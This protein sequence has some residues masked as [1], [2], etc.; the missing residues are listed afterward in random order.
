MSEEPPAA[1]GTTPPVHRISVVVPVYQGERTL[2][3][4][5]EE[6]RPMTAVT[7]SP[8]GRSF[9]IAELILVHDGAADNSHQVM[10]ALAA[11]HPFVSLI[12][13]SRNYGQHPATIAGMA[14]TSADWVVTL[15]E[16]GLQNPADIGKLLDCALESNLPLVYAR[17]IN[18]P[19]H[20]WVRN[21]LSALTK[22]ACSWLVGSRRLGQFNSFRLVKGE[23]A[24]SLAAYCGN[25]VFLDVALSWVVPDCA[26]CPV[27]L[28]QERG[29][30]SG[31]SLPK[32]VS[33]FWRL[34]VT[35]GTTPL[36]FISLLGCLSIFAGLGISAYVL[37]QKLRHEIPVQ[38]W[39]PLVVVISV[40]SGMIL[41]AM[42]V[43]AEYLGLTLTMAMG[44]PLYLIVSQPSRRD[45]RSP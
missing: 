25:G 31:Y 21:S 30:S 15:D 4:L 38:G 5:T 43:V 32:L 41:F 44:K 40:F 33:H 6:I 3:A 7:A 45:V 29:R 12:W 23:V 22:L 37:W 36:R 42:G 19:P 39:T 14:S 10:Q 34:I 16:D 13:L 17:P 24:R 8:G 27:Q 9:Q 18:P 26:A 11:K 35:S 28:R 1:S 20:G 2:D